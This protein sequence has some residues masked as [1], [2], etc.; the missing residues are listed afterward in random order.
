MA[1]SL[2]KQIAFYSLK[3]KIKK[4]LALFFLENLFVFLF[5]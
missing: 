5:F 1:P 4:T 2:Q 3:K